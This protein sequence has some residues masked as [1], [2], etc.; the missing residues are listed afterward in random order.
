MMGECFICG[1]SAEKGQ[2]CHLHQRCEQ[3]PLADAVLRELSRTRKRGLEST[4]TWNQWVDALQYF[5]VGSPDAIKGGV[6]TFGCAYCRSP[7]FGGG[8]KKVRPV[9]I[10]HWLPVSQG[11]GT[12]VL[13][14]V[15][16]CW[17]C[18]EAKMALTG[19]EYF[20]V[21]ITRWRAENAAENYQ[22]ALEYFERV[23]NGTV[24][25]GI[26]KNWAQQ[27]VKTGW[28]WAIERHGNP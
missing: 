28:S 14:C 10:E 25:E 27:I 4:L 5:I 12:T 15:P 20:K 22:H 26:E 8:G 18:N 2:Y 19:D 13:N 7:I 17:D 3:R 11:G 9:T 1:E 24:F 6:V 16:V 23:R 21:M